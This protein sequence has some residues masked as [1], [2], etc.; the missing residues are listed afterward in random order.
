VRAL[1]QCATQV[2]R[3]V[4]ILF[5]AAAVVVSA[6]LPAGALLAF[7]ALAATVLLFL[8]V[9]GRRDGVG[10]IVELSWTLL[11][12]RFHR[13]AFAL[14]ILG[15]L[16]A[17]AAAS[18]QGWLASPRFGVGL[19]YLLGIA[20]AATCIL[21]SYLRPRRYWL[22]DKGI[23]CVTTTV[24]GSLENRSVVAAR[25]IA[26]WADLVSFEVGQDEI[27]L[28][29]RTDEHHGDRLLGSAETKVPLVGLTS[30]RPTETNAELA[31]QIVARIRHYGAAAS[32]VRRVK[33][34][35]TGV[36]QIR[37]RSNLTYRQRRRLDLFLVRNWSFGLYAAILL[38]TIPS[39]L[40][41]KDA[42]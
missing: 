37:G 40:T 41:G 28:R 36:W 22:T 31:G 32:E 14:G 10:G 13:R 35:L 19:R 29:L 4:L 26:M 1:W 30:D 21:A 17:L 39:V 18:M 16:G 7:F 8:P 6:W 5:I 12:S 20:L 24:L 33:P 11:P 3:T 25:P 34:G 42:W 15:L 38:A 2:R 23:F 27:V 9:P